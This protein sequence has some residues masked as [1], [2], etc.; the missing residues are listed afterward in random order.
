MISLR[1]WLGTTDHPH[2]C[3]HLAQSGK[4]LALAPSSN[5][6]AR[7]NNRQQRTGA[8]IRKN[9]TRV[10]HLLL[11]Q[12]QDMCELGFLGEFVVGAVK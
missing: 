8:T 4:V 7:S 6:L 5:G 2:G 12:M 9:P 1:S 11:A 3:I 10:V